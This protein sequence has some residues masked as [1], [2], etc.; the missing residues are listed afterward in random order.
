MTATHL[1]LLTAA[2]GHLLCGYCDCL[3]TYVPGGRKVSFAQLHDNEKMRSTFAK[4]E[5]SSPLVSML[6]GC[7]ALLMCACGY[8]ALSEWMEQYSHTRAVIMLAAS[9]LFL[10][11][12]AAH[13]VFCGVTEW[14][15]IRMDMTEEARKACVEFFKKT[16]PTMYMCYLGL[17][18]FSA[19][20]LVTIA[21]GITSLP[22]WSCIF[23]GVLISAV[24]LPL[25]IGGA[26]NWAGAIMFFGLL[27]LII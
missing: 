1:L 9:A 17:I 22:I 25:R 23:N 12:G 15:Y 5:L 3:I 8:Y 4:M 24:L 14:F 6:L 7:I 27:F 20:L 13:H 26:G 18:V 19:V 10:I 11:P 16:L 21:S 2:L